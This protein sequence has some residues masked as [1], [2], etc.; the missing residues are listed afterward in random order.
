[1]IIRLRQLLKQQ[2]GFTLVELLVV[3]A[4]IGILAA[5]AVPKFADSTKAAKGAKI[6]ADLRSIDSAI[7]LYSANNGVDAKTV[8]KAKAENY[9]TWPT[10]TVVASDVVL[11]NGKSFTITAPGYAI[12]NGRATF[13]GKTV[14]AYTAPAVTPAD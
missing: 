6:V 4:I 11:V 1:M 8:D 13:D 3:V 10:T 5:I 12:T 7:M 9:I 14:D 2:K